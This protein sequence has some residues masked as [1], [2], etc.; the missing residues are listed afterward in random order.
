MRLIVDSLIAVMVL[1][2]L[3][4]VLWY[5]H[6]RGSEGL[7]EGA[8]REALVRL[9]EEAVYRGALARAGK[10]GGGGGGGA[11]VLGGVFPRVW[12]A[13]WFEGEAG[14]VPLN[15]LAS[16]GRVWLDVA[17]LGDEHD[18]PPD[19]V[20]SEDPTSLGSQGGFWCNPERGVLRARTPRLESD[21]ATLELYNRINGTDLAALPRELDVSRSSTPM[22]ASPRPP[23]LA[24]GGED[25]GER[26]GLKGAIS[27]LPGVF[28][29]PV[30]SGPPPPRRGP[31]RT[32][33]DLAEGSGEER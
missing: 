4:S 5:R 29:G 7:R 3:A 20:L 11:G 17:A 30:R 25:K 12:E 24:V 22:R 15:P 18:H 26:E 23:D 16:A 8:V 27:P 33:G 31:R 10:G 6:D 19:P 9:R 2:V 13:G 32:L 14:G 21:R 1:G 28:L